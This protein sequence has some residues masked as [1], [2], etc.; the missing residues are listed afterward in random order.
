M[1]ENGKKRPAVSEAGRRK[2]A[3]RA[4][5]AATAL[6]E[7]LRRRKAQQRDRAAARR[8]DGEADR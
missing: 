7:N 6:R 3:E 8:G 1:T 2:A 5:R 4:A